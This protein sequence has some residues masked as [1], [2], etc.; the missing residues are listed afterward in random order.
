M[1]KEE[2]KAD[3]LIWQILL[4]GWI[5]VFAGGGAWLTRQEAR[6]NSA[7]E[8]MGSRGERLVAIETNMRYLVDSIREMRSDVKEI[9]QMVK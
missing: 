3:K 6:M 2:Y 8:L 1:T 4:V 5:V 7:E 9:K